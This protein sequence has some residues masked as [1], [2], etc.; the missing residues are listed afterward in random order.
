MALANPPYFGDFSIAEKFVASA[1]RSLR[2]GGR[3]VLVTKQPN[4]YSENLPRWF[5]DCEVFSSRRYYIASG[6]K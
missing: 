6:V 5:N 1:H 4:W 3:L 2:K